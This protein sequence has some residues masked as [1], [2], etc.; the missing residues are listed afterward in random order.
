MIATGYATLHRQAAAISRDLRALRH[1]AETEAQPLR[2]ALD[3]ARALNKTLD[4]WQE[5]LNKRPRRDTLVLVSRQGGKGEAATVLALATMLG[6][7]GSKVLTVSRSERQAKRLHRRIR[8]AYHR[9]PNVPPPITDTATELELRNGSIA[10]ALPGSEATIRGEDAVDLAI[11]DEASRVPDD[12]YR[13]VRPMLA[14]TNGVVVAL[15]TPFGKRGWFYEEWTNGGAD[16]HRIKV[17][18]EQ[19][20]RI[21]PAFLAKERRALGE[22]WFRQEYGCEFLDNEWQLFSTALVAAAADDDLLPLF[23]QPTIA[24]VAEGADDDLTLL[25]AEVPV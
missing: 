25:F 24:S 13:A 15:T 19:I 20:P 21:S 10:L 6:D 16:W 5:D 1:S 7:P 23:P 14:T 2:A 22:W 17:T 18:A 4:G 3:I 11:I 12:L 8:R 9:L